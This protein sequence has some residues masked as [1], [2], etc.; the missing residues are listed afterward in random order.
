MLASHTC[1]NL[2]QPVYRTLY[3][4]LCCNVDYVNNKTI[5]FIQVNQTNIHKKFHFDENFNRY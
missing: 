4:N 5:T 3:H 2:I 1:E